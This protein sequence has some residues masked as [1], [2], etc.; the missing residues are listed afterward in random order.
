MTT[1]PFLNDRQAFSAMQQYI[2]VVGEWTLDGCNHI[3][4][5]IRHP[6]FTS[7]IASH[8][9]AERPISALKLSLIPALTFQ[10]PP[11]F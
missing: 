10:P 3:S 5:A 11:I 4:G 6:F 1:Y 8:E 9:Y 7:C 2:D